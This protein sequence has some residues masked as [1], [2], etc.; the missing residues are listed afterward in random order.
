MGSHK[1]ATFEEGSNEP[2]T[3]FQVNNEA[4]R[5]VDVKSKDAT[6]EEGRNETARRDLRARTRRTTRRRR[7][8][9]WNF[10]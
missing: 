5:A 3:L 1:Y 8:I 4:P 10:R 9:D 6:A 7:A 2:P